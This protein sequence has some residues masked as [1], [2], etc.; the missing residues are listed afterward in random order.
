MNKIEIIIVS[1]NNN[2]Y[3]IIIMDPFPEI[4]NDIQ[5]VKQIIE[6]GT[7][8]IN[9]KYGEWQQTLL[10]YAVEER[11]IEMVK[12][13]VES[14]ADIDMEG[15]YRDTP[16][17]NAVSFGDI[18]M[19]KCL[20][21][22]GAEV[23]IEDHLV[24]ALDHFG[25]PWTP[26]VN[27]FLDHGA[28]PNYILDNTQTLLHFTAYCDD[29]NIEH[30]KCLVEHG[31]DVNAVDDHGRTPLF[32]AAGN[33]YVQIVKYLLENGADKDIC[34]NDGKTAAVHAREIEKIFSRNYKMHIEAA[35]FIEAYED[36]PT[37]GV[38]C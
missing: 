28:D 4:N 2:I 1:L 33:G 29:E 21:D 10:L 8:D 25:G 30:V 7:V 24:L 6:S 15:M 13:L 5:I 12:Y 3:S 36:M 22:L 35:E 31:A 32:H 23:D 26:I 18:D 20:V 38:N 9:K 19:V 17:T 11:N 37:K 14:G 34:N 27:Y 16:L